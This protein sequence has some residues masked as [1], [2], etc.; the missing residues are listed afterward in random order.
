MTMS[1]NRSTVTFE[2]EAIEQARTFKA[3]FA[4]PQDAPGP[5]TLLGRDDRPVT[6][7]REVAVVF[8][9]VLDAMARGG[10]V[11]IST[12][13]EEMTTSYA[14]DQLSISRP[15]LMKMIERG[16]I[17]A[18][19]VGTHWRLYT[20][21]VMAALEVRRQAEFAAFLERRDLDEELGIDT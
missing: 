7:P 3:D 18:H 1:L 21:D 6:L 14:A 16:E 8:G 19:R 20:K 4:W 17:P 9:A 2:N 15:T 11:T 13:P 12:V 10:T 5:V